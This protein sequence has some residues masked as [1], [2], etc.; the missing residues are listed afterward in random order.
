MREKDPFFFKRAKY[1]LSYHLIQESWVKEKKTYKNEESKVFFFILG[2]AILDEKKNNTE[3]ISFI[4]YLVFL[5]GLMKN[6][7]LT[8]FRSIVLLLGESGVRA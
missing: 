1:V 7:L 3:N 6:T 8:L 4:F 5:G 2:S